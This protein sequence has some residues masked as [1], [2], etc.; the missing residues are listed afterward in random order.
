MYFVLL[1]IVFQWLLI[2]ITF[3][4]IIH[5]YYSIFLFFY[6]FE[7]PENKQFKEKSNFTSKLLRSLTK[8]KWHIIRNWNE[9]WCMHWTSAFQ[10]YFPNF[11]I[12]A[13][14][15]FYFYYYYIFFISRVQSSW[16]KNQYL[17]NACHM[18]QFSDISDRVSNVKLKKWIW[19]KCHTLFRSTIFFK[20]ELLLLWNFPC[21]S[22]VG[23]S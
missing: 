21:G 4:R 23:N 3:L 18:I 19:F 17:I 1:N 6:I 5:F 14:R 13:E 8:K 10:I 7:L 2:W 15:T 22:E 12:S 9:K 11:N 16:Y 20:I